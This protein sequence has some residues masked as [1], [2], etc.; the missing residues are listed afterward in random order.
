MKQT[1]KKHVKTEVKEARHK[2]SMLESMLRPPNPRPAAH[3]VWPLPN[4]LT[5]L[6][7]RLVLCQRADGRITRKYPE[8]SLQDLVKVNS[9][10]Q[11][12]QERRQST[13]KTLWSGN[14]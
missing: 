3:A 5:S 4:D 7:L 14:S 6:S 11:K 9:Q 1:N 13:R 12:P 10:L 2:G 8:Q